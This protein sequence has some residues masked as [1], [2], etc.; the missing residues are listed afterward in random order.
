MLSIAH[1]KNIAHDA[2]PGF[3]PF[4]K[5]AAISRNPDVIVTGLSS[6]IGFFTKSPEWRTTNAVKHK[7]IHVINSDLLFRAGPR[8]AEGLK[9]LAGK[10]D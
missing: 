3:V 10:L 9:Q 2:R 5:E 1:A 6:D 8:L 7:R 4:S